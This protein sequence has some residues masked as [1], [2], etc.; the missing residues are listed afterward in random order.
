MNIEVGKYTIRSDGFCL[1]I[2]EEYKTKGKDGKAKTATRRVAG[3]ATSYE[4]LLK[5][6]CK[7]R[8]LDSDAETVE[9]LVRTIK[10][11]FDDMVELD[12]GAVRADCEELL[13]EAR[14]QRQ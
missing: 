1:W 9:E 4:N 5:Q 10:R 12:K 3:Y 11:T 14:M 7:N 13:N 2:D 6:F 8:L